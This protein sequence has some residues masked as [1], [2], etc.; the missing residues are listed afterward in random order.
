MSINTTLPTVT[1]E[2][3]HEF[4]QTIEAASPEL[5]ELLFA[6][7]QIML[8]GD[9]QDTTLSPRDAAERLG[10]SRTH[11]YK[12]LDRGDIPS[13]RV[14]RDRRISLREVIA[15]EEQRH[16]DSRELAERFAST[17]QTRAGAIDEI[18]ALLSES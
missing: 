7:R 16:R 6:L 8:P 2:V 13:H 4:D 11:L 12:L 10:M 15:F 1:A 9:D 18:V 5:R 17:D 14:G 3:L